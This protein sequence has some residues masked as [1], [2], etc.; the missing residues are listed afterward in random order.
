MTQGEPSHWL[1]RAEVTDKSSFPVF[2]E[3]GV[4]AGEGREGGASLHGCNGC[5]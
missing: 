4:L 3:L 2:A 5:L 1:G